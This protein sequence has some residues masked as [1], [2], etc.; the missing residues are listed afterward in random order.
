M[1][2]LS[3][4]TTRTRIA[5]AAVVIGLLIVIMALSRG[6]VADANASVTL[7]DDAARREYITALGYTLDEAQPQ[8]QEVTLPADFD[9]TLSQYNTLQQQ[10]G[11]NLD[12]Y[13]GKRVKCYTYTVT[14]L[15]AAAVAHLYVYK[16]AV[17]GGDIT[18]KAAGDFCYPLTP[19]AAE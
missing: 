15:P 16:D 2:V 18:S 10:A 3:M 8:V 9:D 19:S 12:A 13:R 14:G 6:T 7:S 1:F 11:F 17:I 4:K 5:V